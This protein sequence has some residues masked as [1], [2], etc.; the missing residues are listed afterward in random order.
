MFL[1]FLFIVLL[2]IAFYAVLVV[3]GVYI[4]R[5]LRVYRQTFQKK[6]A[7]KVLVCFC[8]FVCLC[9]L[10]LTEP[11]VKPRLELSSVVNMYTF[12]EGIESNGIYYDFDIGYASGY[13]GCVNVNTFKNEQKELFRYGEVDGIEIYYK[14]YKCYRWGTTTH[15]PL[16]IDLLG[17]PDATDFAEV[18]LVTEDKIGYIRLDYNNQDFNFGTFFCGIVH[19][20]FVYRPKIDFDDILSNFGN[21]QGM[22]K[23]N[24]GNQ[25]HQSVVSDGTMSRSQNNQG[26]AED[27]NK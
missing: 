20:L 22:A 19:P 24:Q 1:A 23:T 14:P 3:L 6:Y 25:L 27:S 10:G 13:T 12:L 21:N 4:Y 5:Q 2:R 9:F 7:V 18:Y 16:P 26:T 11:E 17:V 15:L 8:V